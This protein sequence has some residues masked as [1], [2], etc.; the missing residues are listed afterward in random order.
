MSV[1]RFIGTLAAGPFDVVYEIEICI[2]FEFVRQAKSSAKMRF[3]RRNPFHVNHIQRIDL[4]TRAQWNSYVT[5]YWRLAI[6]KPKAY[7]SRAFMEAARAVSEYSFLC[8]FM[9]A[10]LQ[11]HN[12]NHNNNHHTL[13]RPQF[14]YELK[15]LMIHF[16]ITN[17]K[18]L[19]WW[20]ND[21]GMFWR[22]T[23]SLLLCYKGL[24][25]QHSIATL[26][27]QYKKRQH[28]QELWSCLSDFRHQY[29]PN[30]DDNCK[31]I[32]RANRVVGC[33]WG[34]YIVNN[35]FPKFGFF[36][37]VIFVF[38]SSLLH[39]YFICINA[40]ATTLRVDISRIK[41]RHY[42]SRFAIRISDAA[43]TRHTSIVLFFFIGNTPPQPI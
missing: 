23:M 5:L 24:Q 19:L 40:H 7:G 32:G 8:V 41:R 36:L 4:D 2:V 14:Y 33:L 13:S 18:T 10:R 30:E 21:V 16:L 39:F 17:G 26:R 3:A 43:L 34:Q 9:N 35:H 25:Q 6:R 20:L 38:K 42:I 27:I 11:P 31:S 15:I 28:S 12:K 37:M 22:I 1:V 29:W